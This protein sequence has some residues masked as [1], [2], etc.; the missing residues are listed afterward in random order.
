MKRARI[1]HADPETLD[2][3]PPWL[4]GAAARARRARRRADQLRRGRRARRARRARRRAARPRPASLAQGVDAGRQRPLDELV[5]SSRARTARL[6]AARLSRSSTADEAY[7]RLW[8]EL[9]HVLRL[10]EPDPAA[11]WDERIAAAEDARAEALNE[12]RFD[13]IE[14]Q[15]PGTEL[16]V[17]LL[18]TLV[19]AGRRLRD[20]D[21][22]PAPAEPADRGGLHGARPA[23]GRRARHLDE[24]ARA[25][26]RDDR[27]RP[28]RALRGRPR[29]RDR[30]R[31]EREALRVRRSRS[32]RARRR[33]GELALVDRAGP[34]R[35]ARHGVLRHAARRE[36]REPHRARRAPTR[37][38]STRRI[39]AALNQSAIHIDFMIGSPELE[40]T[41]VTAR[42]RARARAARR[43]LA[44]LRVRPSAAL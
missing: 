20:A 10:D 19:L 43:R 13:A 33:L 40:V 31:R 18:P 11:A 29:G 21:R 23:P 28:P 4:R 6:G 14:L 32:T 26:G 30:R 22:R 42:R 24:A 17:G 44:D 5:R 27:P 15:G 37:S 3:V 34:D 16:T 1:E 7:E 8:S 39:A 36:R 41:G 35:P 9:W 25:Q 38:R 12:R 2:F